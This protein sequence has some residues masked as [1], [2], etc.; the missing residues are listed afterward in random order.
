MTDYGVTPSKL[1][2]LQ[3]GLEDRKLD[4]NLSNY[5]QLG[6][7]GSGGFKSRLEK[8]IREKIITLEDLPRLTNQCVCGQLIVKKLYY[9]TFD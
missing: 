2:R 7:V 9:P 3:K 1:D 5:N 6:E 4:T 8:N